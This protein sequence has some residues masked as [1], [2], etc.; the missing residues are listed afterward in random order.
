MSDQL[1]TIDT[2]NDT[3]KTFVITRFSAYDEWLFC[4]DVRAAMGAGMMGAGEWDLT[5]SVS[6]MMAFFK[7]KIEGALPDSENPEHD[8]RRMI[9]MALRYVSTQDFKRLSDK[10]M[11]TIKFVNNDGNYVAIIP[12]VQIT[13]VNTIQLLLGKSLLLH[14]AFLVGANP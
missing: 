7:A 5:I 14:C 6:S 13:D 1:I 10:L 12:D 3:G 9:N 4:Q 11:T 8:L 2:G